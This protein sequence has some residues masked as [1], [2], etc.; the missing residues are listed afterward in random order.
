MATGLFSK[1][2]DCNA[3]FKPYELVRKVG[4]GFFQH[5]KLCTEQRRAAG[6]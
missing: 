3:E 6:A 2:V 5:V 4:P 1:C